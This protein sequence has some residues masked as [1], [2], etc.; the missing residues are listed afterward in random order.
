MTDPVFCVIDVETTGLDIGN[1]YLLEIGAMAL[2]KDLDPMGPQFKQIV[3]FVGD[4]TV[5]EDVV[6]EM[7]TEN[8]LWDLCRKSR[9]PVFN[10]VLD[11]TSWCEEVFGN[12]LG[13][14]YAIGNT[15][16]F[17]I[18]VLEERGLP[19]EKLFHYR[20]VDLSSIK[21]LCEQWRPE[22]LTNPARPESKK[23]HRSIP[24]CYDSIVEG[25]YF[26]DNLFF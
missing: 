8:G 25:Q 11:F 21:V 24:D 1:D 16:R 14:V 5:F 17:D 10:A 4:H 22:L 12:N 2:D 18:G 13:K 23:L 3:Q 15:I 19:F 7:H 6:Q 20:S 26:R 9:V